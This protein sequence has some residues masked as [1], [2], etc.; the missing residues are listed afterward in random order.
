MLTPERH[1]LILTL[2]EEKHTIR[3]QE[4]IDHTDASESTI[5]RDLATLEKKGKLRRVHGGASSL[6]FTKEEAPM[7]E[8]SEKFHEEKEIIATLAARYIR[9]KETIFLDAG[10]TTNLMIPHLDPSITVVTNG[11]EHL[12]MLAEQGI[13]TYLI[14]GFVKPGTR[15]VIG[16]NAVENLS[17]YRFDR[18]FLG[19]NGITAEDGLTTP[20]PEEAAI[21]KNVLHQS[22]NRYVLADHS[23]FGARTFTRFAGTEEAVLITDTSSPMVE[24]LQK[25]TE[26][27]VIH[28]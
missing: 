11:P 6:S 14:G 25:N 21:K 20:D 2:L 23:K 15:A 18:C 5:R 7:S 10:S 9:E 3:L 24:A 19:V 16:A 12:P 27:E 17:Q 8:K 13:T 4:L 1:Q 26:I 22:L 28:P